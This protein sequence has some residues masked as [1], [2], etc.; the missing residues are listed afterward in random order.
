[1]IRRLR[2]LSAVLVLLNAGFALHWASTGQP[3]LA[4]FSLFAAVFGALGLGL[5]LGSDSQR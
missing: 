1:M 2:L 5:G 4:F 3:V